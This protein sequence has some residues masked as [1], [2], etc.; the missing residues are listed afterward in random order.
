M[1]YSLDND[2][3]R[4]VWADTESGKGVI[5]YMKDEFNNECP[6]DFKNIQFVRTADWFSNNNTW[7]ESIFEENPQEDKWFYTFSWINENEGCEDL[8]IVG[9]TLYNDDEY[10]SGVFGNK[11]LECSNSNYFLY[12]DINNSLFALSKNIFVSSYFLYEDNIFYGCHSNMLSI[13]CVFNTFGNICSSNTF[14]NDCIDNTF[15]NSCI[16]NKFDNFCGF[17]TFSNNCGSN[18]FGENCRSNTFGNDCSDNTFGNSCSDNT[19]GNDCND[20][21][22]GISCS[23]NAFGDDCSSNM[24]DN[25]INNTFGNNCKNNTIGTNCNI[26]E[27]DNNCKFNTFGNNCR[28]IKLITDNEA[29]TDE[30]HY[31]K[32]TSGLEGPSPDDMLE[33]TLEPNLK[34]ETKVAKRTNG[35]IV[36]YNEA[37]L[38]PWTY[39]SE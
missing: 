5:Y 8:S 18:T 13:N 35:E 11:I 12:S 24:F 30:Y 38:V 16:S 1:K 15:G 7:Y 26:I 14:G 28:C 33:I 27:I 32:F 4:F 36:I 29:M 9:N 31:Y 6:Y 19:F 2:T 37:D 23:S 21:I 34:Y 17:N 39:I 3:S 10:I 25:A 22:F 20:N